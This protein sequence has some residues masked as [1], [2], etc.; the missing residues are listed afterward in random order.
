MID[1]TDR[2]ANSS[3]SL[4]ETAHK[5]HLVGRVGRPKDIGKACLFLASDETSFIMGA[6]LIIYG[7]MTRKMIYVE[8][9]W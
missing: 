8:K 1:V 9:R 4:S 6:N 5:K 7:G 2:G 3:S